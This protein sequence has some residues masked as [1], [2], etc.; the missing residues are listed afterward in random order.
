MYN[1]NVA[2]DDDEG[3]ADSRPTGDS[4][5][6]R[7]RSA[8]SRTPVTRRERDPSAQRRNDRGRSQSRDNAGTSTFH[9]TVEQR[10]A[11]ERGGK[12]AAQKLRFL[13]YEL[14]GHGQNP[15]SSRRHAMSSGP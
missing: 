2:G 3:G 15:F 11:V 4:G 12:L 8:N 5:K 9:L 10:E 1:Y 13:P 14:I 7:V 6:G